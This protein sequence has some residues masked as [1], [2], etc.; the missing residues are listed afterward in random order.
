MTELRFSVLDIAPE[1][2]AVVPTLVARLQVEETT[3]EP[4]HALALRAQVRIDAQRRRYDDDEAVGCSTSSARRS[5]GARRSAAAVD[6]HDRDGAG[7]HGRHRGRAGA[8]VHVRLRGVGREVPQ[9]A[10]RRR[11]PL[12]LLFSG[13]VFTRG[14]T[15]FA[16]TQ[17][18]WDRETSYRLP[19]AVWREVMDRY[20]PGSQWL[21]LDRDTVEALTRF[22]SERGLPTW[23][24]TF[25][26]LLAEAGQVAR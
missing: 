17:V 14:S 4:V 6:A 8:A 23:E 13:T 16:V 15:G 24:E 2:Y 20:F 9:R 19:V 3:G 22:K 12:L 26:A 11:D 1:P 10:A 18:P 5:A 7:L 21:R 25:A